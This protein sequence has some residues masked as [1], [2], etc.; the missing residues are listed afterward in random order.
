MES[1]VAGKL[2]KQPMKV[3]SG[4]G[5]SSGKL[6]FHHLAEKDVYVLLES[7]N[8]GKGRESEQL[9]LGPGLLG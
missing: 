4:E 9:L 8:T 5:V 3:R 7:S 6:T 2:L 1:L